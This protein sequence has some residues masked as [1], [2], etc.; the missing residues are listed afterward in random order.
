VGINGDDDFVFLNLENDFWGEGRMK[1]FPLGPLIGQKVDPIDIVI[2]AHGMED[3]TDLNIDIPAIFMNQRNVF[4]L[5]FP[6]FTRSKFFH[7]GAA[8][9]RKAIAF[10][11]NSDEESTFFAFKESCHFE[12][13]LCSPNRL[14]RL[15]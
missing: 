12:A 1:R 7:R 4:F 14:L 10:V 13:S 15:F 2:L 11:E 9:F 8:A 6:A 3:R 5:A